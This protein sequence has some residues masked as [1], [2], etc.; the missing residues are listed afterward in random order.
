VP[1]GQ[2]YP[3]GADQFLIS[4]RGNDKQIIVSIDQPNDRGQRDL[5]IGWANQVRSNR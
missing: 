5:H 4:G 1:Q 2:E 3:G